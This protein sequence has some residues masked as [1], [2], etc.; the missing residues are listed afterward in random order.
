MSKRARITLDLDPEPAKTEAVVASAPGTA[1]TAAP[2]TGMGA[3]TKAEAAPRAKPRTEP[4]ARPAPGARPDAEAESIKKRSQEPASVERP[5]VKAAR[6]AGPARN[7]VADAGHRPHPSS[8]S[9]S[10]PGR[11]AQPPMPPSGMLNLGTVLKVAV[12]SLAVVS[13]VLWLKRRP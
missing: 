9:Y 1:S 5:E 3:E 8:E 2:T 4:R 11:A 13:V 10:K 7:K 12:V 6:A